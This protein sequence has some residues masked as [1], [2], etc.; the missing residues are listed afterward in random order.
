[1]AQTQI[2]EEQAVDAHQAGK[3]YKRGLDKTSKWRTSNP[4]VLALKGSQ[5]FKHLGSM[6]PKDF[7]KYHKINPV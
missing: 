4:V 6:G 3:S 7:S 1:M 5:T 2:S